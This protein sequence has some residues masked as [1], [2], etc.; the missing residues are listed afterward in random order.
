MTAYAYKLIEEQVADYDTKRADITSL[1]SAIRKV[2]FNVSGGK[3]DRG[4][5]PILQFLRHCR[6]AIAHGGKMTFKG[7]EPT[8]PASWRGLKITR[9]LAGTPLFKTLNDIE[10]GLM[11]PGDVIALLWD[12]EQSYVF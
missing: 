1:T 6:H 12:I 8:H 5:D 9:D 7:S 4:K 11:W 10:A 3:N 2:I